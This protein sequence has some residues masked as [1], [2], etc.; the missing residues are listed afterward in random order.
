M[1][2]PNN[3][4]I[5]KSTPGVLVKS[6]FNRIGNLFKKPEYR[7]KLLVFVLVGLV[8]FLSAIL[9]QDEFWSEVMLQLALTFAAVAFVQVLWDF[10]GGDPLELKL[11]EY[12]QSLKLLA[13]LMDENAGIERIWLKR[14]MWQEDPEEGRKVWHDRVCRADNVRILSNTL[15]NVWLKDTDFREAFFN[16]LRRGAKIKI[17]LY[18]PLSKALVL[19][20]EDEK[21]TTEIAEMQTEIYKSLSAISEEVQKLDPEAKKRFE[22]GLTEKFLHFSQ[23]I[24]ADERILVALYLSKKGGSDAPT[25]QLCGEGSKLY[26]TYNDQFDI[27]WE[28]TT[29]INENDLQTLINRL[30]ERLQAPLSI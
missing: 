26:D 13:D 15:W 9:V 25:L 3:R 29:K 24:Q 11:E 6:L 20:A 18:H 16:N 10:L 4:V 8:L 23:I 12:Q 1:G 14:K 28:R 17:V 7:T 22:L 30:K 21:S 27:V 2:H 19:R 5:P